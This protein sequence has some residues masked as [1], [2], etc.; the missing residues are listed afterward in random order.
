MKF[1][2]RTLKS[3]VSNALEKSRKT[4]KVTSPIFIARSMSSRSLIRIVTVEWFSLYAD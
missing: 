2:F 1:V 3:M 4:A